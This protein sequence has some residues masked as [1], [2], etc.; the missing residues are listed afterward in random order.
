MT[1]HDIT[2]QIRKN[3]RFRRNTPVKLPNNNNNNNNKGLLV[4]HVN[5]GSSMLSLA[6]YK[7]VT[8]I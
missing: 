6:I 4:F 1:D 2:I 5:N 7:Q 3:I 8:I